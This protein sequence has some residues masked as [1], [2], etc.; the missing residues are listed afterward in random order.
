MTVTDESILIPV[1]PEVV[2]DYLDNPSNFPVFDPTILSAELDGDGP[3][4]VG[5]RI[6]G[7]NKILGQTFGWTVE[8]T[9]HDRPTRLAVK[10]VEGKIAFTTTYTLS[11]EAG[12]TRLHYRNESP[13]GLGD[14]FGDTPE[15]DLADVGSRQMR[16]NLAALSE[17]LTDHR[18]GG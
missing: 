10:T 14:V 8:V 16:A 15:A 3:V 1:P 18:Q 17:I 12:G 9:D 2:F 11:P 5:S 13:A 4:R 6:K 7:V